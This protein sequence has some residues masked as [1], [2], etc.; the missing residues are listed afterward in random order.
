M[1]TLDDA[2]DWYDSTRKNLERMNRLARK[3]WDALP[4]DSDIGRDDDFRL[5]EADIV[6]SETE[7]SLQFMDD[8]AVVV[9]FSVF[10][11]IVRDHVKSEVL[12]EIDRISHPFLRKAA[13]EA[14]EQIEVGSFARVVEPYKAQ[15][16][17]LIEEVN[18]VRRYRNWVAHG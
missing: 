13:D 1:K 7:T 2:R 12:V 8:L 6:R 16:A 3:Y 4:W 9:L 10:E 14:T 11:Q 15:D 5:L 18:Q 17:N